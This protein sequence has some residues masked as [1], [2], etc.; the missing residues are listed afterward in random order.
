M[1][2]GRSAGPGDEESLDPDLPVGRDFDEPEKASLLVIDPDMGRRRGR[3]GRRQHPALAQVQRVRRI[4]PQLGQ[5][6]ESAV[7]RLQPC[8]AGI[9]VCRRQRRL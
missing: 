3:V 1:P 8:V 4:Q 5:I 7:H 6:R 9:G 2:S